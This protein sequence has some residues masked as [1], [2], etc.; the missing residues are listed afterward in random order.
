VPHLCQCASASASAR[1]NRPTWSFTML[2]SKLC[3]VRK[4]SRLVAASHWVITGRFTASG[5]TDR[6]GGMVPCRP[7]GPLLRCT[8]QATRSTRVTRPPQ[9]TAAH[10]AHRSPTSPR[11]RRPEVCL[12]SWGGLG[13]L[14]VRVLGRSES[15]RL[16]LGT[17]FQG[18]ARRFVA[19]H[20]D[21]SSSYARA[22]L[23][24]SESSLTIH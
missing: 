23:E 19:E 16:K 14:G 9:R 2:H 20:R 21:T 15:L 10:A 5:M 12:W 4:E 18:D 1:A 22:Q 24:E 6:L 8:Y 7:T 13:G 11:P 3:N 17:A